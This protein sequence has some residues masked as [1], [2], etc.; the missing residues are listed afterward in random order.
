MQV[1]VA[2]P[3]LKL[4]LEL[5]NVI[6]M[7]PES[8]G[9]IDMWQPLLWNSL[10]LN[11]CLALG[12]SDLLLCLPL[13]CKNLKDKATSAVIF[14]SDAKCTNCHMWTWTYKE[15]TKVI[16]L[17]TLALLDS[18]IWQHN[19]TQVKLARLNEGISWGNMATSN[20]LKVGGTPIQCFQYLVLWL[21]LSMLS[22]TAA[23]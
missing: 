12:Q 14:T 21:L 11:L 6:I 13:Y 3:L 5:A 23:N 1:Q 16:G 7:R 19:V 18:T 8:G 2:S 22:C 9:I 10:H 4:S 20:L 15:S 17:D